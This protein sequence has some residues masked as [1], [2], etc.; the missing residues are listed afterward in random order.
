M[1]I[2][3]WIA[4]YERCEVEC[5]DDH[6]DPL[7][8][9]QDVEKEKDAVEEEVEDEDEVEEEQEMCDFHVLAAMGP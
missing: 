3:G 7:T 9:D 8:T 6:D 2:I 1:R 4:A 5:G